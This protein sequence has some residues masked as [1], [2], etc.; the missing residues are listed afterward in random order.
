MNGENPCTVLPQ[1]ALCGRG[2]IAGN[3]NQKKDAGKISLAVRIVDKF[4]DD[5]LR[6]TAAAVV[7]ALGRRAFVFG[8]LVLVI[9]SIGVFLPCWICLRWLPGLLVAPLGVSPASVIPRA[10]T[11]GPTLPL[12]LPAL[13]TGLAFRGGG[14]RLGGLGRLAAGLRWL[15]VLFCHICQTD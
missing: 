8:L 1:N 5:L 13:R 15:L 11:V 12:V 2:T 6:G 10:V 14:V 3:E 7:S 9:F 4:L